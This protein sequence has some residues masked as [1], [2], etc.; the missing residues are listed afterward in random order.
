MGFTKTE[1]HIL[2]RKTSIT[3][4]AR[5][6]VSMHCHTKHSKEM[7]DFIPHY[8]DKLPVIS[9]FWRKENLK[10]EEKNGKPIGFADSH[11]SPPMTAEGVY[12]SERK[13]IEGAGLNA[14]VSITDHD[15]IDG[16]ANAGN[17]SSPETA[18]ISMEWTVPYDYGFF[19]LGVNGLPAEKADELTKMLLGY[20]FSSQPPNSERLTQILETLNEIDSV[21]VVLNHP[22]WDIE[23]VGDDR[24][25]KL[26]KDFLAA[27]GQWLHALEIN[28]FRSWSENKEV[29][30]LAEAYLMPVVS[31][32]D[33]HGCQPNTV[34]NVTNA[35]TFSEFVEEVR[36]DRRSEVVIMP[37][38]QLPLHS[39]QLQA[40]SEI[41]DFYPDFPE[42]RRRWFDRV[43]FDLGDERGAIPLSSHGWKRGG[44]IWL[45]GAIWTLAFLGSPLARPMFDLVVKNKDRVSR[46]IQQAISIRPNLALSPKLSSRV[47]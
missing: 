5:T 26:L 23:L 14:L 46:D 18:P 27:N 29:L 30:E 9:H 4:L 41:L 43:F 45:R 2:Q 42:E 12:A 22:L 21:L 44:P 34:I 1:V 7:L 24:H 40:F 33:R 13:Q 37:E 10:F 20:T 19:H 15:S 32:G 25:R 38:Y 35:A 31:G 28:G 39:R 11:W 17:G 3:S 36:V 8:A 6:G 47:A 16:A